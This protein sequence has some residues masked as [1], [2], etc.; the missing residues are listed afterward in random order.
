MNR[1]EF[2][3]F[4]SVTLLAHR[5]RPVDLARRLK[6][7]TGYV[8]QLMKGENVTIETVQKIA[9]ALDLDLYLHFPGRK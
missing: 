8:A 9:S 5:V 3:N 4:L 6:C 2:G 7:S 1:A